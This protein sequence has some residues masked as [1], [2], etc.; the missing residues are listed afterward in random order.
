VTRCDREERYVIIPHIIWEHIVVCSNSEDSGS[1]MVQPRFTPLL[2]TV[3]GKV[4]L[5]Y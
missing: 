4:T 5:D 1:L 3:E 2:N